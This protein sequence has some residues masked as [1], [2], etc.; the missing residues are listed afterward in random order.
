[1]HGAGQRKRVLQQLAGHALG[2]VAVGQQVDAH[3]AGR[4]ARGR[5]HGLGDAPQ[6]R[7]ADDDAVHHD[8]DRVL[9]L[10][11]ELYLLI[12][13][14]HLAVDAHAREALA[15]QVVEQL[16]VL[17]LAAE[18]HRREHERA[19]PLAGSE[20]LVGHL[21]GR[22]ALDDASA[23]RAVRRAHA[24]VEQAQVVVDLRHGAHGGAGVLARCLLVDG[25]GRRQAVDGVQVWLVHL[26][27]ELARVAREA[28]DVAALA[29][30]VDGVE[31]QA[32]LARARQARD[33]HEL[34]TRD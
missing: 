19:A 3:L 2:V 7:L 4:E 21:V 14:A 24:G 26:A 10:L 11:V 25:D 13:L 32:R 33:D 23:L 31:R 9:E 15:A 18:D 28:L 6:A 5:L 30:R 29:L 17:A 34:V 16:G 22:L 12:E 27:E 1:M 20:D 8:L